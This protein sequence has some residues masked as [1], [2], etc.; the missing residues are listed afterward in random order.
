MAWT[1]GLGAAAG[2]GAVGQ[3]GGRAAAQAATGRTFSV[4]TYGATGNGTSDDATGI[5][6]ALDAAANGGGL[7]TF[8]AGTFRT[9]RA[10]KIGSNTTVQMTPQTTVL[11][12]FAVGDTWGATFCN[13]NQAQP[14]N[15][16]ITITGGV[17]RAKGPSATGKHLGFRWVDGLRVEGTRFAGVYGDWNTALMGVSNVILTGLNMDSGTA[18]YED[19]IH[20]SGG[21]LIT[22]SNCVIKCGDDAISLA[23][24]WASDGDIEDVT[25]ENCTLDSAHANGVRIY[26]NT[27]R[28]V[29]RV[30]IRGVTGTSRA[31]HAIAIE[32]TAG[33]ARV[34]DITIDGVSMDAS[35]SPA[36]AVH[37]KGVRNIRLA[38][39]SL[40]RTGGRPYHIESCTDVFASRCEGA[41]STAGMQSLLALN[42]TNVNIDTIV[43]RGATQHGI[44]YSGVLGGTI[45]ACGVFTSGDTGIQLSNS[46]G[47]R[48]S[49]N[50]CS[51]N[52]WGMRVDSGS[53]YNA[54]QNNDL[55]GNSAGVLIGVPGAHDAWVNNVGRDV[56]TRALLPGVECGVSGPGS[57][58]GAGGTLPVAPI[59]PTE[60][61]KR[62]YN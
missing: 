28:E 8:P 42:S 52:A 31:S 24:E 10:L 11:R 59:A 5:Q 26:S 17:L 18:L 51:G 33:A 16:A 23:Q 15:T 50:Q 54:V 55:S 62:G 2:L 56:P 47:V 35:R 49:D 40:G 37:L 32:D 13:A 14:G 3:G 48:V 46:T 4:T 41:P 43:S 39:V 34:H 38:N 29:R 22:I 57:K 27:T 53:D 58:G 30:V 1:A 60:P 25:I 36:S 9:T 20:I 45:R 44:V 19:G 7:V 21:R 61:E 12:D 6:A